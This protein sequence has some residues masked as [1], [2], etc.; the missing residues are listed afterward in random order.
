MFYY[1]S[2]R[3]LRGTPK[4]GTSGVKRALA[5]IDAYKAHPYLPEKDYSINKYQKPVLKGLDLAVTGGVGQMIADRLH[6]QKA[7]PIALGM[8]AAGG[9]P[10]RASVNKAIGSQIFSVPDYAELARLTHPSV[11]NLQDALATAKMGFNSPETI[12]RKNKITRQSASKLGIFP[13]RPIKSRRYGPRPSDPSSVLRRQERDR[14]YGKPPAW[15]A[16]EMKSFL[17]NLG[18]HPKRGPSNMPLQNK[19]LFNY[20]YKGRN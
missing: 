11:R 12:I 20:L 15:P 6:G 2:V 19:L 14:I 3:D 17:E 16:I 8:M 1:Y 10:S 13:D 4:K 9:G 18:I 7:N 5:L